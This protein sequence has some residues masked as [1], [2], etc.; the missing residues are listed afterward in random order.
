MQSY[1]IHSGKP[2]VHVAINNLVGHI[3]TCKKLHIKVFNVIVGH[4]STG[5]THKIKTETLTF[6]EEAKEKKQIKAFICGNEID[7]FNNKYQKLEDKYKKLLEKDNR[8]FNPGVIYI[9]L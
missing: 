2:S 5:G 4:G 8:N 1:D 7:I 6:L 3:N 9:W